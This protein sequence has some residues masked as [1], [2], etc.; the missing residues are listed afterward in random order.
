VRELSKRPNQN[1][2][3]CDFCPSGWASNKDAKCAACKER[4]K[5]AGCGNKTDSTIRK[6]GL[7]RLCSDCKREMDKKPKFDYRDMR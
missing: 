5:C 4:D 1:Y 7:I 3:E 6:I 2:F